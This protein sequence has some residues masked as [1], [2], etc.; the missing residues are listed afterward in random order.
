[1]STT[2]T[3]R[4]GSM[5][6]SQLMW[7]YGI[8]AMIDL[9]RLSVMVEGLEQWNLDEARLISEERLLAAVRRVLGPQ[10]AEL[11]EPPL[12]EGETFDLDA[13]DPALRIGVPVGV[14]PRWLR[15][16]RCGLL[17]R[18]ET[19]VFSFKPEPWRPDESR[20]VHDR[21]SKRKNGPPPSCVPARFLVACAAGHLD[22]FPWHEFVHRGPSTCDGTLRF[23]EV[24]SSLETANLFV[25]CDNGQGFPSTDADD[26]HHGTDSGCGMRPRSLV[27]AFGKSRE[28]SLP[29]CRGRHPHLR[30][31]TGRCDQ[32]LEAILLGSSSSWFP[33]AVSA[34]SIP[35]AA[36]EL[37]QIVEDNWAMFSKID[38]I[39]EVAV[40]RKFEQLR[41]AAKFGDEEIWAAISSQ[42]DTDP[43]DIEDDDIRLPEWNVLSDP[44]AAPA[45]DDFM[46]TMG[47]V[48]LD[49]EAWFQ[50][51]I[52]VEKI[53]EVNALVGFTRLEA[54]EEIAR[55][56][57]D[58][59]F[60]P[61]SI[62]PPRWVPANE[63]RGEG[64]L[65]RLQPEAVARWES[66]L[67]VGEH[68]RS[69]IDANTA[70]R[71]ARR[72]PDVD[73]G[74]P[75]HRYVLLHS[76]AHLL[77]RELALECGYSSASIRERIYASPSDE[78]DMCGVLIYT[79][80]PDSEG[81]LGGLVRL[82]E[83]RMLGH[84]IR[85]AVR[86]AQLCAAD[87]LCSE[88]DPVPDRVLHAAACHACTFAPETACECGNRFLDRA[89]AVPTVSSPAV[90]FFEG[91]GNAEQR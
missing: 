46:V 34:I 19:E 59:S 6:P 42:R 33:K 69:L 90:S 63:V 83:A 13:T 7:S 39:D 40:M 16:P 64:I 27:E 86:H 88:H 43:G 54:P 76:F 47:D 55:G 68:L 26:V 91:L 12:P 3:T 14:F 38:S 78:G 49:L 58:L 21:C 18:A 80:A 71:R 75:G 20:F 36:T 67:D 81:T 52:L 9:P 62:D 17:T 82:G 37:G 24:G 11:R 30:H 41:A 79:A 73:V 8:G 53:R 48:P 56:G 50:P 4:V 1:M 66:R 74:Y 5:R 61:L 45:G 84:L 72:F 32:Q 65:V 87:P 51:T 89:V 44:A 31:A 23:Y 25:A 60:A 85:Q 15:C 10:V 57:R 70:W 2:H 22:D 29:K 28:T 77:M 35:T